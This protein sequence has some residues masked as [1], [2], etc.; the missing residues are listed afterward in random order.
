MVVIRQLAP[1]LEK[2]TCW[3][4]LHALIVLI[5]LAG[6]LSRGQCSGLE[7]QKN[8]VPYFFGLHTAPA[9]EKEQSPGCVAAKSNLDCPVDALGGAQGRFCSIRKQTFSHPLRGNKNRFAS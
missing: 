6:L 4:A 5:V 9:A 3:T 1:G 8:A 2:V 7:R